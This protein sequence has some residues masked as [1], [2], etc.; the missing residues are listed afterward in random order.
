MQCMKIQKVD[1]I[2]VES[3]SR[4]RVRA[5]T[6]A[7]WPAAMAINPSCEFGCLVRLQDTGNPILLPP[8]TIIIILHLKGTG[9][10]FLH[11]Y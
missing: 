11:C 5:A 4:V 6:V 2:V 1:N 9:G 8:H 3:Q 10:T 7:T